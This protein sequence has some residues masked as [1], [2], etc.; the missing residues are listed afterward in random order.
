MQ[1]NCNNDDDDNNNIIFI[2]H[3]YHNNNNILL[4]KR[5]NTSPICIIKFGLKKHPVKVLFSVHFN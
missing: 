4:I 1:G 3:Y 2:H 5:L